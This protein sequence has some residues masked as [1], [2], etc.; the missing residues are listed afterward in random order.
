[1]KNVRVAWSLPTT[2]ESG[3]PLDPTA[4]QHVEVSLSADLGANFVALNDVVP[5]TLDLLIPDVEI[6]DWVVRLVV[7]DVDG[8]RSADVDTPFN[9]PDETNPA[10]VQTV[11]ITFE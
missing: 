3:L 8:R 5:P 11:T 10:A 6:C 9:V 2:R 4:I 1:M 7:V